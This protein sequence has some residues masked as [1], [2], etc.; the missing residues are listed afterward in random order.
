MPQ[1]K[2]KVAAE[3]MKDYAYAQKSEFVE[4]MQSQ[5]TEINRDVE[6]LSAKIERRIQ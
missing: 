4:K 6:K 5:L 3:E 1:M 2:A